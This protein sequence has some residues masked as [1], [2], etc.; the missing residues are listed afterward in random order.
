MSGKR[1]T[2]GFYHDEKV[3]VGVVLENYPAIKEAFAGDIVLLK[4]PIRISEEMYQ[5]LGIGNN[6]K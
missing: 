4:T 6:K 1:K 5:S 2:R 3:V